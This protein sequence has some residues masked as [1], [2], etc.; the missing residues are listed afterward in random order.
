VGR[1]IFLL[2]HADPKLKALKAAFEKDQRDA[3][4]VRNHFYEQE[5]LRHIALPPAELRA[6]CIPALK[7]ANARFNMA[8]GAVNSNGARFATALYRTQTAVL[9]N[10]AD[11]IDNRRLLLDIQDE[12]DAIFYAGMAGSAKAWIDMVTTLKSSCV[13]EQSGPPDPSAKQ[14]GEP[15]ADNCPPE[16]AGVKFTIKHEYATFTVNCEK[17]ELELVAKVGSAGGLDLGVFGSAEL[18][19]HSGKVT[20]FGGPKGSLKWPGTQIGG[21][22]K[23]GIYVTVSKNGFEDAGVR[24]SVSAQAALDEGFGVKASDKLDFSFVGSPSL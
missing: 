2:E 8:M 13:V 22:V 12:A 3:D 10:L 20:I 9:A 24:V 23:D 18:N 6:W 15:A 11:R 16:V 1:T 4:E 14:P 21:S 19:F 17:L 5:Y 7:A